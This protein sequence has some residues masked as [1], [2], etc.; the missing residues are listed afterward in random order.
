ME[1]VTLL[2]GLNRC[3]TEYLWEVGCVLLL[4]IFL[5]FFV[6]SCGGFRSICKKSHGQGDD[7]DDGQ[8]S[9]SM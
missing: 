5:F 3:I 1:S 7:D 4:G 6:A 9:G 8:G 2:C